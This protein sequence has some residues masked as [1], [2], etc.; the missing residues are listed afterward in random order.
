M[1]S[2]QRSDSSRLRRKPKP[3][4]QDNNKNNTTNT[5][6]K[7]NGNHKDSQHNQQNGQTHNPEQRQKQHPNHRNSPDQ[8]YQNSSK[9]SQLQF[10]ATSQPKPSSQPPQ[11]DPLPRTPLP[12]PEFNSIEIEQ[13]LQ[14]SWNASCDQTKDPKIVVYQDSSKAWGTD[15]KPSFLSNFNFSAELKKSYISTYGRYPRFAPKPEKTANQTTSSSDDT[16]HASENIKNVNNGINSNTDSINIDNTPNGIADST[17]N[18]IPNGTTHDDDINAAGEAADDDINAAGDAEVPS[19]A[20]ETPTENGNVT[21]DDDVAVPDPATSSPH[22]AETYN[23]DEYEEISDPTEESTDV[24]IDIPDDGTSPATNSNKK[25]KKKPKKGK[26]KQKHVNN[27]ADFDEFEIG[28]GHTKHNNVIINNHNSNNTINNN[29]Y[30]NNSNSIVVPNNNKEAW[31]D[32]L[33]TLLPRPK[34]EMFKTSGTGTLNLDISGNSQFSMETLQTTNPNTGF[35]PQLL[36][37]V[38]REVVRV[39]AN[40]FE[41][42]GTSSTET[43]IP[44]K[45]SSG[46][47]LSAMRKFPV[48]VPFFLKDMLSVKPSRSSCGNLKCQNTTSEDKPFKTCAKCNTTAYCSRECQKEDWVKRHKLNCKSNATAAE[49]Q[50]KNYA[51]QKLWTTSAIRQLIYLHWYAR[52]GKGVVVMMCKDFLVY[53]ED[54]PSSR[55]MYIF[56]MPMTDLMS[57][58]CPI[59]SLKKCQSEFTKSFVSH[60]SESQYIASAAVDS[61]GFITTHIDDVKLLQ[62][63]INKR[64]C[65]EHDLQKVDAICFDNHSHVTL[66]TFH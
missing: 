40:R 55:D 37:G 3:T 5:T 65:K 47:G 58:D 22:D 42:S 16:N 33:G 20:G 10:Q 57:E 44:V 7:A 6:N 4:E 56:Y 36:N 19:S 39:F 21:P 54:D 30:H 1:S 64:A 24:V 34:T 26:S 53:N 46:E 18:T 28:N 13:H 17:N 25:A 51:T 59:P 48:E 11:I 23:Q 52:H 50:R 2:N 29:N 66:Y 60:D 8:R 12:A 14:Q 15:T 62:L 32:F 61:T 27:N 63:K 31:S 49:E 9:Q 43:N 38:P 41:K 45:W 35:T